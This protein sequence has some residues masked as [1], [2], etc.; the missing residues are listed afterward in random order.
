MVMSSGSAAN[1]TYYEVENRRGRDAFYMH[2]FDEDLAN[3]AVVNQMAKI[4]AGDLKST[5]CV[6]MKKNID[7]MQVDMKYVLY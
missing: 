4:Y 7:R 6:T 2:H 3:V 5:S 1:M